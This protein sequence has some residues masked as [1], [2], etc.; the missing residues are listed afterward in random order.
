M[1]KRNSNQ[2]KAKSDKSSSPAKSS[3][4][5]TRMAHGM[6][7]EIKAAN[8]RRMARIAGQVRGITAM[9]DEERYC[10]DV[11]QQITAAQNALRAVA[12]ETLRNHLKHCVA[13]AMNG[14]K[15][16]SEC[17]QEELLKLFEKRG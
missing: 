9:I 4:T 13:K 15:E 14:T 8:L 11:L 1:A 2:L 6:D 3:D 5:A 17:M 12:K 7:A 16:E 10:A